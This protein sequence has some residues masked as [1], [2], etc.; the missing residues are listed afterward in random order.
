MT[1]NM[2]WTNACLLYEYVWENLSDYLLPLQTRPPPPVVVRE[3]VDNANSKT[4]TLV[5]TA[6][7]KTEE[8]SKSDT[9][10][11]VSDIPLDNTSTHR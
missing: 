11:E 10:E 6:E 5:D 2:K 1:Y 8:L 9:H 3:D 4:E 7:S